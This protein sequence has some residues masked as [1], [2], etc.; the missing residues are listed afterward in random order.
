MASS[1]DSPGKFSIPKDFL[2]QLGKNKKAKAF[3]KTLNRTNWYSI[4]WRLQTAKRPETRA[5]RMKAIL[6]MLA[7][8][9]KFH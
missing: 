2:N 5:R 9:V 6:A 7:K 3:F 8:E 4:A 1:Y